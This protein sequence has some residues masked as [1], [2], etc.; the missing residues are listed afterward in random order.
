MNITAFM[1]SLLEWFDLCLLSLDLCAFLKIILILTKV[2]RTIPG[3]H[4]RHVRVAHIH[5]TMTTDRWSM[6]SVLVVAI[7]M[8]MFSKIADLEWNNCSIIQA[9]MCILS[10]TGTGVDH[11]IEIIVI[12]KN[13][14]F[15]CFNS[16]FAECF[17][18]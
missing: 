14:N 17:N 15:I 18:E 8:E 6:A 2:I 3:Q 7:L 11:F 9:I 13:E 5:I 10:Q 12:T 1:W 4:R 16:I